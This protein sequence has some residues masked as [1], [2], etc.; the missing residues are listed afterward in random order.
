MTATAQPNATPDGVQFN[1]PKADDAYA[2]ETLEEL[3]SAPSTA[4]LTQGKHGV[5]D[6]QGHEI[7]RISEQ[8]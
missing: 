2:L 4:R 3:Y 7:M 6:S 8:V 5:C 1:N